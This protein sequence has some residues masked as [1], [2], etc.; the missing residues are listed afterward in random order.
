MHLSST[1]KVYLVVSILVLVM[2]TI[3]YLYASFQGGDA[4]QFGGFLLNPIDGNSYLAKMR[5]G[6][7]GS[8]KFALPYTANPGKGAYLFLFYI[9]LGH[10][11]RLLQI[12]LLIMFHGVK[13]IGTALMLMSM[14]RFFDLTLETP[15][16]KQSAFCLAALGSGLGWTVIPWG[17]FTA[18]FWVAEAYPFLSAYANPHFPIGLAITLYLIQPGEKNRIYVMGIMTALLA[19]ILPFGVVILIVLHGTLVLDEFF[20]EPYHKITDV[21]KPKHMKY[22]WVIGGIGLPFLIY[23]WWV[24]NADPVLSLWNE[25]NLTPSPPLWDTLLSFSPA[26]ILAI[27]GIRKAWETK[28]KKPLVYWGILG[29]ALMYFPWSLQR[30]FMLGYYVPMAGLA[31]LGIEHISK[32]LQVRFK[33]MVIVLMIFVVPTNAI[34]ILSGVQ[35]VKQRTPQIFLTQ[36]EVQALEWVNKNAREDD[37][38]LSS[39]TTGLYIP[40]YTGR[41]VYYGHPFETTEAKQKLGKAEGFF[42]EPWTSDQRKSFLVEN[43]IDYVFYGP[44]EKQLGGVKD[45]A[46]LEVVYDRGGIMIYEVDH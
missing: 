32:N 9:S 45:L 11:A 41:Q 12:P 33:S 30:R 14:A 5:Q 31:V 25:Q 13:F 28:N 20:S 42:K 19:L 44:R 22:V 8:W 38:I 4:Y 29:V 10:L 6:W 2:V 40:A 36:K 24:T 16:L 26:L 15:R 17:L 3:P 7:N 34:V 21:F 35:A 43:E 39:P 37:V 46:Y 18:D 1:N 23:D 27:W